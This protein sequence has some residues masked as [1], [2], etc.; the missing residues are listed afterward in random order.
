MPPVGL[1]TR[2]ILEDLKQVRF[3]L[4]TCSGSAC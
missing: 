3:S 4:F 2:A 1:A